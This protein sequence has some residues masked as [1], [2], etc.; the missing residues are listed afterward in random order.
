MELRSR[1]EMA[2]NFLLGKRSLK[3]KWFH[4]TPVYVI[5]CLNLKQQVLRCFKYVCLEVAKS[6][7]MDVNHKF[8]KG[9]D[10]RTLGH[11]FQNDNRKRCDDL[12]SW[13][14]RD[15][16]PNSN[17]TMKTCCWWWLQL[18]LWLLVLVSLLLLA[19][20]FDNKLT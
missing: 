4:F 20:H 10:Y 8:R 13:I 3:K 6:E 11:V 2:F 17:I 16:H 18:L 1:C 15:M 12:F 5:K 9:C 14:K 7:G 19:S